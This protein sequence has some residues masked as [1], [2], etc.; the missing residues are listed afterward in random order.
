MPAMPPERS[1]FTTP[2]IVA[3]S[4]SAAS[5]SVAPS[6]ETSPSTPSLTRSPISVGTG[7]YIVLLQGRDAGDPLFLQVKEATTSVLEDHLPMSRYKQP[8]ERVVQGQRMSDT[9]RSHCAATTAEIDASS[10]RLPRH[11]VS[12]QSRPGSGVARPIDPRR[13]C[14]MISTAWDLVWTPSLL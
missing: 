2:R 4:S 13:S 9:R 7:A 1:A 3:T 6:A 11:E 10:A 5:W 14:T 12:P 8:G